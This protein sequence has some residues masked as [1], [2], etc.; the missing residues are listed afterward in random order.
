MWKLEYFVFLF[1]V[2]CSSF[3]RSKKRTTTEIMDLGK[4]KVPL[5]AFHSGTH[6]TPV[7]NP[8]D[9]RRFVRLCYVA[10][11]SKW[12]KK[13]IQR[14]LNMTTGCAIYIFLTLCAVWLAAT[15]F[16]IAQEIFFHR[17]HRGLNENSVHVDVVFFVSFSATQSFDRTEKFNK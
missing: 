5:S 14:C 12:K 2:I 8:I 4:R 16:L 15:R 9:E 17:F 1:S 13:W 3:C 11:Y 6:S 7:S 10:I